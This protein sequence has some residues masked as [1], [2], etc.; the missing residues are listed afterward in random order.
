[1][2]QAKRYDQNTCWLYLYN[3]VCLSFIEVKYKINSGRQ[4]QYYTENMAFGVINN[5]STRL[6]TIERDGK[7]H[8]LTHT[9]TESEIESVKNNQNGMK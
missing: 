9:D 2:S 6:K 5:V 7:W 3:L 1:M 4:Q 8:T